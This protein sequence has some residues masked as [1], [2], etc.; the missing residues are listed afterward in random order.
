MTIGDR[1][2]KLFEVDIG[3]GSK[4]GMTVQIGEGPTTSLLGGRRLSVSDDAYSFIEP[5]LARSI[6]DYHPDT[7]W[8]VRQAEAESW[9]TAAVDFRALAARLAEGGSLAAD[10]IAWVHTVDLDTNVEIDAETFRQEIDT[11]EGH[12]A[13]GA[14]LLTVA[15][16]IE[17]ALKRETVLTI[18]GY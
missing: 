7:R 13:L 1:L 17:D 16:W 12:E 9:R 8:G 15:D 14:F 18:Y 6:A 10:D 5:V 4:G 11:R 3:V 2:T